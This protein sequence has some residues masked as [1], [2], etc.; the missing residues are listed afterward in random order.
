MK[1]DTLLQASAD[2][3]WKPPEHIRRIA[4]LK[5]KIKVSTNLP[6]NQPIMRETV[7]LKRVL[8]RILKEYC[9]ISIE[10]VCSGFARL[11]ATAILLAKV[12]IAAPVLLVG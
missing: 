8:S 12:F 11:M 6:V 3:R 9:M 2:L 4:K 5:K 10:C 1:I 7:K